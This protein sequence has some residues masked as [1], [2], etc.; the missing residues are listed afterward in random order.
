MHGIGAKKAGEKVSGIFFSTTKTLKMGHSPKQRKRIQVL[1]SINVNLLIFHVLL[2]GKK[3]LSRSIF[4]SLY[5][6]IP[7]L[8]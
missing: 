5:N 3:I 2:S 1:G 4:Y 7:F 6:K 8:G